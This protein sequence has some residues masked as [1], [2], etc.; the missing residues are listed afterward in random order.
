[1]LRDGWTI[2]RRELGHVRRDPGQLIAAVIFPAIMV[3]LFGGAIK[4]PGGAGIRSP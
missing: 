2:T 3:L 1:M 4:V